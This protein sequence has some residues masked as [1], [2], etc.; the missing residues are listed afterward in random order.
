M[1]T[2]RLQSL[3]ET[4][5]Y[6]W[7]RNTQKEILNSLLSDFPQR[8]IGG[9][10]EEKLIVVFGKTQVGK[11]TVILSLMGIIEDER[12]AEI[13]KILRAGRMKGNSSTSTATIYRRSDDAQFGISEHGLNDVNVNNMVKCDAEKFTNYLIEIRKKVEAKKRGTAKVLY[14]YIPKN[15]FSENKAYDNINILDVPGYESRNEKEKDHVNSILKKY[16]TVS[17]LNIVVCELNHIN[18][19]RDFVAPNGER[20]EYMRHKYIVITTRSY[21]QENIK[22]YFNGKR[23]C[24]F[25]EYLMGICK[26]EFKKIFHAQVPIFFP[27]DVGQSFYTL[28]HE[29]ISHREDQEYLV[30]YRKKVFDEIS[31]CIQEKKGN[32]LL[33]WI[34]EV[35]ENISLLQK[36]K[37]EIIAKQIEGLSVQ[38]EEKNRMLAE[39][40]IQR[41]DI[42]TICDDFV[43]KRNHYENERKKACALNVEKTL[44]EEIN[45]ILDEYFTD[46]YE[47][48]KKEGTNSAAVLF[49]ERFSQII[50]RYVSALSAEIITWLKK[51]KDFGAIWRMMK[52][53]CAKN[54]SNP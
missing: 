51:K 35:K 23:S 33:G 52:F 17:A 32:R 38:I 54:W 4:E 14:L 49:A 42:N 46:A 37:L 3:L 10:R 11:T 31:K 16:M 50:Y 25:E 20:L 19:L 21:S 24:T 6:L 12:Q 8:N 26:Q 30:N 48:K 36:D 5:R 43:R 41:N 22:N 2:M 40:N 27:V 7:Q 47:W 45:C 53:H 34:K 29:K 13:S 15:Y 39:A 9:K 44:E 1:M 18:A 28:I